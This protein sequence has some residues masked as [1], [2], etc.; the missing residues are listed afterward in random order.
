MKKQEYELNGIHIT[1]YENGQSMATKDGCTGNSD[2]GVQWAILDL[3]EKLKKK[4]LS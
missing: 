3:M 1:E 4:E 2:R